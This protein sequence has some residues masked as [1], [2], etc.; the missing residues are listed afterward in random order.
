MLFRG[1]S[2]AVESALS[3]TALI[4]IVSDADVGA[5]ERAAASPVMALPV[6]VSSTVPPGWDP[7]GADISLW[8]PAVPGR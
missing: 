3:D 6:K 4:V 1:V 8:T 7:Q 5:R 2:V